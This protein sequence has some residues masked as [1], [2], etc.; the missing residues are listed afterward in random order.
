YAA[1]S[2]RWGEAAS[3]VKSVG[4][5]PHVLSSLDV[6]TTFGAASAMSVSS[7]V[8]SGAADERF[9]TG[10]KTVFNIPGYE[11]SAKGRSSNLFCSPVP[12]IGGAS[13]N[14]YNPN[15]YEANPAAYDGTTELSDVSAVN[16]I[17][18][19]ALFRDIPGDADQNQKM[20]GLLYGNSFH[21]ISIEN[22]NGPIYIRHFF[23]DG[24]V[25]NQV[26][27]TTQKIDIGVEITNSK[28]VLE[29]CTAARCKKAG[30]QFNNSRVTVT[31]GIVGWRNYELSSNIARNTSSVG[32]GIRA[33]NSDIHFSATVESFQGDATNA[34]SIDFLVHFARNDV[35][36]DLQNSRMTGG[37]GLPAAA[38]TDAAEVFG[39]VQASHNKIGVKAVNST[40]EVDG[41][42]DVWENDTGI[43][44]DGTNLLTDALTVERNNNFG[45]MARNSCIIYNTR[46]HKIPQLVAGSV[47]NSEVAIEQTF[48]HRNGQHIVLDN[49]ILEPRIVDHMPTHYGNFYMH[50]NHGVS[51]RQRNSLPAVELKNASRATFVHANIRN[52]ALAAS[53]YVADTA[54]YGAAISVKENSKAVFKGSSQAATVLYGPGT[55]DEQKVTAGAYA[56]QNSTIEFNGPTTI[57]RYGVDC[58]ADNHSYI[59][60]NPHRINKSLDV[61]GWTLDVIGNH[62]NIELHST[63]ACL[64][65]DNQSVISMEDLGN[66]SSTWHYA[67]SL[68]GIDYQSGWLAEVVPYTSGGSMQFYPNPQLAAV[69]TASGLTV[70][71]NPT[72]TTEQYAGQPGATGGPGA[73]INYLI[74]NP[75]SGNV[76]ELATVTS[77]GVCVR[78]LGGSHIKVKNVHFPTGYNESETSS[79]IFD[80]S[81]VCSRLYIWN[82]A[83]N[84]TMNAS[85]C[86]VSGLNPASAVYHGPSAV[87]A[88][89]LTGASGAASSTPDTG[90]LSVLDSYGVDPIRVKIPRVN[91]SGIP[92]PGAT[93]IPDVTLGRSSVD[94]SR[95]NR[96][97]FRL[98][99]STK[100]EASEIKI[101]LGTAAGPVDLSSHGAAEQI[102]AQGYNLSGRAGYEAVASALHDNFRLHDDPDQDGTI[103][104]FPESLSGTYQCKDFVADAHDR[105]FLDESAANTFANAK[106]GSLGTSNRP[107]LVSIYKSVT[108]AGGEGYDASAAGFGAGYHSN[109]IFDLER[110]N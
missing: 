32:A 103:E 75:N 54:V 58:L 84:S 38:Q 110:S 33:Y 97:P 71:E 40:I 85:Y 59:K 18:S 62:T 57:A 2:T 100:P 30:F 27:T 65:A 43:Q 37:V 109:N 24:T 79:L 86:S 15:H 25:A 12:S 105:V 34:S 10:V 9:S 36:I 76:A 96:G 73:R 55:Y 46:A 101:G 26:T 99:F 23:V 60:F 92:V 50:Q 41:R 72:F 91:A 13:G 81:A 19:E 42:L 8:F 28:V 83:G 52:F 69:N 77:G 17:S 47:A 22:C 74:K 87:Y 66:F 56:D 7:A 68:S 16:Q 5:Y 21:K 51:K 80:P 14:I 64:V 90:V 29:N 107:K 89:G 20:S 53:G 98:Y 45:I 95:G 102:F 31:R 39:Y 49:S 78:A 3:S 67:S 104:I 6:S 48:F 82:I 106:N 11:A 35:G 4:K 70:G 44:M 108:T 61:S 94:R 1:S 93:L 63:R 88:Q